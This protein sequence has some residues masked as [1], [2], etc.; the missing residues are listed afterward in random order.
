MRVRLDHRKWPDAPHWQHDTERLGADEH[1]TWLGMRSGDRAWRDEDDPK[2]YTAPCVILVPSCAWW[3]AMFNHGH[4]RYEV[5]V[6]ITTPAIAARDRISVIDLDLDVVRRTGGGI[7]ILDEDE[8]E[9]NRRALDY[10]VHIEAGA[11]AACAWIAEQLGS[12]AAPFDGA[13]ERWLD[14]VR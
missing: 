4:P 12:A 3:V 14:L 2:T 13:A 8:F 5:Y 10:P 6:D 7:E 11:R 9:S 1:G